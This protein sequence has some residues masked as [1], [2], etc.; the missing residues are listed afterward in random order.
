MGQKKLTEEQQDLMNKMGFKVQRLF[1]A[2]FILVALILVGAGFFLRYKDSHKYDSYKC[3]DGIIVDY[4][5]SKIPR[6]GTRGNKYDHIYSI[7][8]EYYT[9]DSDKPKYYNNS[10]DAYVL[11]RKGNEVKVYYDED[12]CFIAKKDTLTGLYVPA[13]KNYYQWFT[14]AI[15]PTLIGIYLLLDYRRTKKRVLR[16]EIKKREMVYSRNDPYHRDRH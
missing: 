12:E 11:F 16:G 8:V 6:V 2:A 4:I 5:S 3:T 15:F 9:D 10:A 14:L 13:E 1:G 7:R